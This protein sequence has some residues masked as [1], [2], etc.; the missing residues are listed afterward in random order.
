MPFPRKFFFILF[1]SIPFFAAYVFGSDSCLDG[2]TKV[3]SPFKNLTR[4]ERDV[5]F[6]KVADAIDQKRDRFAKILG[7]FNNT[8]GINYEI[9]HAIRLLKDFNSYEAYFMDHTPDL[10]SVAVYASTNVPLYTLV[11][12][13]ILPSAVSK[14]VWFRTPETTRQV[15]VELLKEL[16]DSLG[17]DALKNLHLLTENEDTQYDLFRK[18][19]VLGLNKKGT[20]VLRPPADVVL[21]VGNQNTAQEIIKQN[22]DKLESAGEKVGAHRQLFLG[23][24]TGMNPVVVLESAKNRIDRT[25]N[26]LLDPITMN[27]AQ[28]CQAPNFHL[29]HKTV[30]KP[31][32]DSLLERIRKMKPGSNTDPQADY[33]PLLY[34]KKIDTLTSYR[35]KYKNY[36]VNPEATLDPASKLVSPHVFVFPYSMFKEVEL[37]EHY[38][39]FLTIFE[40][41]GQ[42]QLGNV[43]KD[44]RVQKQAMFATVIT[45]DMANHTLRETLYTLR[46]ERHNV[47]VNLG[48]YEDRYPNM[49]F[50]GRGTDSSMVVTL[51]Y[52]PGNKVRT[53][54]AHYPILFSEEVE[55]HFGSPVARKTRP[56]KAPE[57][58]VRQ[59]EKLME[60]A[61]VP[62][63]QMETNE[64]AWHDFREPYLG[65][66]PRGIT[67]I[68]KVARERGIHLLL[69]YWV[70]EGQLRE[71]EEFYGMPILVPSW[72]TSDLHRE[73]GVILPLAQVGRSPQQLNRVRGDL[74]PFLG[75]G[76]L[77]GILDGNKKKEYEMA[78][79]IQP[80]IMA[81][82]DTFKDLVDV[83]VISPEFFTKQT[84]LVN[85]LKEISTT[86]NSLTDSERESLRRDLRDL[87]KGLFSDVRKYHPEGAYFKNFQEFATG[88]LGNTITTFSTSPQ[89]V[90]DEFVRRFETCLKLNDNREIFGSPGFTEKMDSDLREIYRKFVQYLLLKPDDVLVQQKMKIE[91][92][93]QGNPME[94]RVDFMDGEAIES[95]LRFGSD[96][97]PDEMREA[98]E[99]V[100]QFFSRAPKYL[101]YLAGGIDIVRLRDGSWK[102]VEFNIGNMSGTMR[103]GFSMVDT[104][105][106][107]SALMG[108]ARHLIKRLD[109]VHALG[110]EEERRFLKSLV[111]EK[112][113]IWKQSL[114]DLSIHEAGKYFRN[115]YLEEWAKSPSRETL[116]VTLAKV[117]ALFEG[118]YSPNNEEIPKLIDGA[119]LYMN[120]VLRKISIENSG[121]VVNSASAME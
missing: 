119:E 53:K 75:W 62:P 28:D 70:P 109:S 57:Y 8:R 116:P 27:C 24:G 84:D 6:G 106:M 12:R 33:S 7:Q 9:H 37:Q 41:E 111:H 22:I 52:K 3:T 43:A 80:G 89:R 67:E 121:I 71:L 47:S 66:R 72:E 73:K 96:Y 114:H 2:L 110:L 25:T 31:L 94:F 98:K 21:F 13:G 113:I 108:E 81:T 117:K 91:R 39:P 34:L 101:K 120:R 93:E 74:N 5:L 59:L 32:V 99:V 76:N 65:D 60:D 56:V 86:K 102:I 69:D 46:K 77:H 4:A 48:A 18:K 26:L 95:K 17:P 105:R 118:L 90:A 36:L 30:K 100:N 54:K 88:D 38:A 68:Q 14:D 103:P 64:P 45:D 1:F 61:R 10:K 87:V 112:E 83:K 44:L 78:E 40:Y 50:G 58:F 51:D 82:T 107:Y 16:Q 97:Y 35:E 49:P 15:Y 115:K 11:A 55:L 79:A 92:T 23:F 29:V 104:Q 19:Y 85:R 20:A 42:D 63:G